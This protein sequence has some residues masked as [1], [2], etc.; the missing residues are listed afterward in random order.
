[1]APRWYD[2]G[3]RVALAVSESGDFVSLGA[4]TE[5]PFQAGGAGVPSGWTQG[6]GSGSVPGD[7]N[8]TTQDGRFSISNA[9][10][11]VSHN[12]LYYWITRDFPVTYGKKYLFQVQ[13]RTMDGKTSAVWEMNYQFQGTGSVYGVN[14]RSQ[15]DWQNASMQVIPGSNQT[16]VRVQLKVNYYRFSGEAEAF[17]WG[18]Q[19]Q[20]MAIVEMDTSAPNPVWHDVICD[21]HEVNVAYGRA[22][23]TGRF[24]VASAQVTVINTDG[25][26]TYQNVHPW[27]LRPGRFVKITMTSPKGTSYPVFYGLIDSINSGYPIDGKNTAVLA[28]LDVSSL[29]SNST[30]PSMTPLN[31]MVWSGSRILY[32]LAAAGWHPSMSYCEQGTYS[33]QGITAN[34]R[35]LR[36]EMGL[37]ADSEGGFFYCNRSGVIEY[38]GRNFLEG[39]TRSTKVYG[40]LMAECPEY[41]NEVQWV[42]PAVSGNSFTLDY[43]PN[44][45][46]T[47]VIDIRARVKINNLSSANRQTFAGQDGRWDFR[48]ADGT[49][50]MQF[51]NT[52]SA[53]TSNA[54]IPAGY[55]GTICWI[56][57]LYNLSN[58]GVQFFIQPDTPNHQPPTVWSGF[59]IG[60][61]VTITG[62]MPAATNQPIRI[63][64]IL[65]GGFPQ[66]FG[67]QIYFLQ[68]WDGAYCRLEIQPS[69]FPG[70]EGSTYLVVPPTANLNPGKVIHVNQ[71]GANKIVQPDPTITP[72]RLVVVDQVPT[73]DPATIQHL[74]SL[75]T[76]WSRDRV[77]NDVQIAN[78]NGGAFRQVDTD[79]QKAYGPRTYQRLDFL[80]D[81]AHPE[82]AQQRIADFINGWTD[83]ILRVNSVTL[84]PDVDTYEWVLSMWLLDLVRVRYQHPTEGWGFAVATYVQGYTHQISLNGWTTVLNLDQPRSFVYWDTP[85]GGIGWDG[86]YWDQGIWD[87]DDPN[88]TYWSSGQVWSDPESKWMA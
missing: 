85:E 82:Y 14:G 59:Q 24:E 55:D 38:H 41:M 74:K 86:D 80:N 56:R 64:D 60:T 22:K 37:G 21:V 68:I 2:D 78:Q 46:F 58:N 54:P 77:V 19:F 6:T 29:L 44:F 5:Y 51:N 52:A 17:D 32:L 4:R 65:A 66:P 81:N 39:N 45:A 1:M 13:A 15:S 40:E 7:V 67:G 20:G 9:S 70:T 33:Q 62:T 43:E 26:F 87:N 49:R 57:C 10:T 42:F 53:V 8:W 18:A 28:C 35:T 63:G 72:Y 27:G 84:V 69:Q 12:A 25:E 79:S 16:F 47:S 75:E 73:A 11:T 30:V 34:G 48:V 61:T 23:F 36:D 88:G 76:D 31:T 71:T 3:C 83:A 50:H